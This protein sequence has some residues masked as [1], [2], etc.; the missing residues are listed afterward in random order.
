MLKYRLIFGALMIVAFTGLL[1]IDGWLDG[2][3]TVSTDDDRPFQGLILGVLICLIQIPAHLE[4]A[5]LARAKSLRIGL[6]VSVI[7][8]LLL[9]TAWYW[10]PCL[11]LSFGQCEMLILAFA[12]PALFFYH[13]HHFGLEGVMGGVGAAWLS[14]IYLGVL[15]GFL[16]GIRIEHG[17]W[18]LLMAIFVV[19]SSDI[20]AYTLGRLIGKHRFSP[21]ISPGKTWEGMLGAVIFAIIVANIFADQGKIMAWPL[22]TLF[23][24]CF[25]FIGQMGDLVE[26]MLKRD[27]QIKD[28]SSRI[29]GF[30][31]VLDVLDSPLV[32]APFAYLFFH[33]SA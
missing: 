7:G 22:A 9:A 29:P 11:A 33:L 23:G 10:H 18:A 2:A 30:G 16:A 14:M 31:G 21:R 19:K 13:V 17:L 15:S 3:I 24:G 28:S 8:S 25:A 27:A 1:I 26:S 32:A 20:G 6:P 4:L 12:L 5:A